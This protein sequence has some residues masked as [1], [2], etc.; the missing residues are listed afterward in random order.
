MRRDPILGGLV[1]VVLVGVA[2]ASMPSA[3]VV[4]IV[5]LAIGLAFVLH[6]ATTEV[7]PSCSQRCRKRLRHTRVDGQADRR[8]SYNPVICSSCHGV[9]K[10][11][12]PEKQS[13]ASVEW[14][15]WH[16]TPNGWLRGLS[17]LD[18]AATTLVEHANT[19]VVYRYTEELSYAGGRPHGRLE[20]LQ[21]IRINAMAEEAAIRYYGRC[22]ASL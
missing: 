5:A 4:G 6:H 12:E 21:S 3:V 7:C 1:L 18:N 2:I 9:W 17:H 20:R 15:E 16:L 10:E 19:V 22:P 8:F 14:T 11:E 13:F